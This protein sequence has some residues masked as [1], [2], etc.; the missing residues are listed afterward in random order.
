M[1]HFGTQPDAI[2]GWDLP[3]EQRKPN[4][5]PLLS[6]MQTY[7]LT[8][9][10]ILVVDDSKLAW[11]MAAPLGVKIAFAAWGKKAFPLLSE[12]MENLCDYTFHSTKELENFLFD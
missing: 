7:D 10:D 4:A 1:T 8:P 11:D 2:Y 9:E 12:E 6:I 3:K 5:Y